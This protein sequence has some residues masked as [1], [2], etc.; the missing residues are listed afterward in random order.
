V[1]TATNL[2]LSADANGNASLL[3]SRPS[4]STTLTF[5]SLGRMVRDRTTGTFPTGSPTRPGQSNVALVDKTQVHP[6]TYAGVLCS[7]SVKRLWR[8]E[9]GWVGA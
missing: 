3:T 6:L 5:D 2:V 1:A 4:L 8:L 7:P 9:I